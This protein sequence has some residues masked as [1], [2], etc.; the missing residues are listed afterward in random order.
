MVNRLG[1]N[2]R[3]L[4]GSEE[5]EVKIL[6]WQAGGM[7]VTSCDGLSDP[8]TGQKSATSLHGPHADRPN[9]VLCEIIKF[10]ESNLESKDRSIDEDEH[11]NACFPL[12][13]KKTWSY[14]DRTCDQTAL[15]TCKY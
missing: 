1:A 5:M 13:A 2:V 14:F 10:S 3:D 7:I 4:Q 11:N 8:L 15:L 9:L 6:V 12:L